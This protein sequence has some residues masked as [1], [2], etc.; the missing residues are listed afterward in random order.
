MT[1]TVI[2]VTDHNLLKQ[3]TFDLDTYTD[4]YKIEQWHSFND[5]MIKSDLIY[6]GND[7]NN[8]AAYDELYSYLHAFIEEMCHRAFNNFDSMFNGLNAVD[9]F[10]NDTQ[11][12]VHNYYK[13]Q[14]IQINISL[15]IDINDY[16]GEDFNLQLAKY[17]ITKFNQFFLK[18]V[19]SITFSAKWYL[20][21]INNNKYK[22]MLDVQNLYKQLDILKGKILNCDHKFM[23]KLALSK[24]VINQVN[25][26][27]L[28][29]HSLK[30]LSKNNFDC[31]NEHSSINKIN[32][33]L[34]DFVKEMIDINFHD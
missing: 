29:V 18:H 1:Q 14:T 32:K 4:S 25:H 34:D 28:Q 15:L 24:N 31:N 7:N 11:I 30:K 20:V 33:G 17:I 3:A 22:L 13:L 16:V 9:N 6:F 8:H 26:L 12:T 2:P 27:Y 21:N 10:I 19:F 23:K 5:D